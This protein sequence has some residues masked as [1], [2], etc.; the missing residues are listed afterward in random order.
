[1][2][3][4]PEARPDAVNIAGKHSYCRCVG[5]GSFPKSACGRLLLPNAHHDSFVT[6]EGSADFGR[7][8]LVV[9]NLPPSQCGRIV[10]SSATACEEVYRAY[11]W[12]DMSERPVVSSIDR[13]R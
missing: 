6:S 12:K 3:R 11:D 13:I 9:A 5:R 10:E 1:M 2:T 8:E 4:H 7:N